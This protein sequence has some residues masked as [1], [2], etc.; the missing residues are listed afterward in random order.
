MRRLRGGRICRAG[1]RLDGRSSDAVEV[2]QN[3][4]HQQEQDESEPGAE[5]DRWG[6]AGRR[7]SVQGL[8]G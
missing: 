2:A 3:S 1:G 7:A 5:K 4:S 8:S 6:L